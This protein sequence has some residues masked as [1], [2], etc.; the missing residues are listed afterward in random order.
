MIHGHCVPQ[1]RL[2]WPLWAHL[3]QNACSAVHWPAF[4]CQG[5]A[6]GMADQLLSVCLAWE[7]HKA[8]HRQV[9]VPGGEDEGGEG[10]ELVAAHKGRVAVPLRTICF[11]LIMHLR[12]CNSG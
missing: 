10:E 4:A 3:R 1:D 2:E 7:G 6:R 12:L 8:A 9:E 5:K 11:T